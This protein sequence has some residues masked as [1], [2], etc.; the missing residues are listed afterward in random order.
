[1]RF[2]RRLFNGLAALS[3]LICVSMAGL[4]MR[5]YWKED[6]F[7]WAGEHSRVDVISSR[8]QFFVSW[9]NEGPG[10]GSTTGFDFYS[11]QATVR[12]SVDLR[13]QRQIEFVGFGAVAD[14]RLVPL[15][16]L[17]LPTWFLAI[18]FA[19]VPSVWLRM[20]RNVRQS[21]TSICAECGYDLRATPDRCPECGTVPAKKGAVRFKGTGDLR[22]Q[23][24]FKGTGPN[25]IQIVHKFAPRRAL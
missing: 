6:W 7:E 12:P 17:F 24:R 11:E 20:Q 9:V 2:R 4:W 16:G 21:L 23:R 22:G 15:Y 3:L 14:N 10:I 5:S 25:A 18:V 1:M 19:F 8:G 13:A